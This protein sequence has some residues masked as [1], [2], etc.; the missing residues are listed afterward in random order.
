MTG[1]LLWPLAATLASLSLVSIG[2]V[3]GLLSE[4]HREVV[5]AHGW[6]TDASR[7]NPLWA[8]GSAPLV[9]GMSQ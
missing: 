3:N 4:I 7:C 9:S 1:K 5:G 2:G 8:I 6:M